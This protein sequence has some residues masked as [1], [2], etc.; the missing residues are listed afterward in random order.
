MRDT[1]EINDVIADASDAEINGESKFP[2]MTYEEGVLATIRW[3]T[4]ESDESPMED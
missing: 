4:G 2:G 3:M 1:G